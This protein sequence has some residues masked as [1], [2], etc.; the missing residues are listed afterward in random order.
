MYRRA[1][2]DGLTWFWRELAKRDEPTFAS[3]FD[4]DGVG[5]ERL[6]QAVADLAHI[7]AIGF[8]RG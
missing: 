7:G 2:L 4:M 3:V 5:V 6:L 8:H 1:R